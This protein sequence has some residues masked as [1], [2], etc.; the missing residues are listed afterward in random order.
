VPAGVLGGN[1]AATESE[2]QERHACGA[3]GPV[4][5]GRCA[6]KPWQFTHGQVKPQELAAPRGEALS[7]FGDIRGARDLQSRGTVIKVSL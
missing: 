2:R 4:G 3:G 5:R 7:A 6:V 1:G